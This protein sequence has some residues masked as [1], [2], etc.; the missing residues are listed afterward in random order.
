MLFACLSIK[1]FEIL[2]DSCQ[3]PDK[4]C[5]TSVSVSRNK[6]QTITKNEGDSDLFL[7]ETLDDV[8]LLF[9]LLFDGVGISD[10]DLVKTKEFTG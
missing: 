10:T 4:N 3:H 6:G 2:L 1:I 9:F 8:G 7:E 5:F